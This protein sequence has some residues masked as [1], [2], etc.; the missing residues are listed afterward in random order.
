MKRLNRDD[1]TPK[2]KKQKEDDTID[3]EDNS[4]CLHLLSQ[5]EL[6]VISQEISRTIQSE[7]LRFFCISS[8]N[9]N[10]YEI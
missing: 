1:V 6:P 7:M 4:L 5:I 3:P 9:T 10:E 2:P 8:K